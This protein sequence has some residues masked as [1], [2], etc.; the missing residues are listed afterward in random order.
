MSGDTYT[1]LQQPAGAYATPG[2]SAGYG[3]S[4]SPRPPQPGQRTTRAQWIAKAQNEFITYK[5]Q[6]PGRLTDYDAK[7]LNFQITASYAKMYLTNPSIFKWAGMAAF[8]SKEVGNGMA[9]AWELGFGAGTQT[10]TPAAVWIGGIV[11]GRGG[12]VGPR[13][14][15]LLFWALTGGN[16]LVWHDIC[17]QHL[18]YRDSGIATLEAAHQAGELPGDSFTAWSMID[19]GAKKNAIEDVWMG[20]AL[21]L[22]YEQQQVLQPQIY[23]A[24]EVKDLWLAI[25]PD[26]PTPIP[27]HGVN[28]TSYV[29]G[30]NIGNFIDRWKWIFESMLPAWRTLETDSP[31]WTKKLIG[32]MR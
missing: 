3:P 15:K 6:V 5:R 22:K 23:D 16:R 13:M 21:L 1:P 8:A 10:F 30:G 11:A 20:N 14:G 29:P 2:G 31:A 28:F 12:N 24:K 26:V 27:G 19:S 32:A 17:W 4:Q 25:S 7:Q 9:Q 18:A